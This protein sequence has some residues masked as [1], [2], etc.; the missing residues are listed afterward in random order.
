[1]HS[2]ETTRAGVKKSDGGAENAGAK[3]KDKIVSDA[4][5]IPTENKKP[6]NI[7]PAHKALGCLIPKRE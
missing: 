1:V 2:K 4:N 6:Q 5:M 7:A 3:F